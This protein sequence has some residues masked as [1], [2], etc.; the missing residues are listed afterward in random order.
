MKTAHQN[1]CFLCLLPSLFPKVWN[2]NLVWK[3]GLLTAIIQISIFN[4]S[5][6]PKAF[7]AVFIDEE[8]F[9]AFTCSQGVVSSLKLENL[10]FGFGYVRRQLEE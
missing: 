5:G 4:F 6:A 7:S 9:I 2:Q 3:A 1:E 10:S 8:L